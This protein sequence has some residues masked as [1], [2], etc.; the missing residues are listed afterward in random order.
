VDDPGLLQAQ[1]AAPSWAGAAEEVF[2][3]D[4]A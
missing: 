4:A 1:A 2:A 3:E